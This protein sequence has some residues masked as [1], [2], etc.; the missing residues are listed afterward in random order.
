MK[1]DKRIYIFIFSSIFIF[2][3]IYIIKRTYKEGF[4]DEKIPKLIIQT[5]KNKDIPKQY[6]HLVDN[7]KNMN[8]TYE[9]KLYT[10]DDI[11]DFLKKNY[12]YYWKTFNRLPIFIQKMDFF[13]YIAIYHNGGFYFDLDIDFKFPIDDFLLDKECIFPVDETINPKACNQY[14]FE[15]FCENKMSILLGQYA[16]A[17]KPFNPFIKQLIDNIHNNIENIIN[18]NNKFE[19]TLYSR[20]VKQIFVYLTTG[21]DYVTQQYMNSN[22]KSQIFILDNSPNQH[23]GKYAEHK[24]FGTWK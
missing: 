17:S 2:I 15:Y 3:L 20:E 22:D 6:K 14:R 5:W 21:P 16:F 18:E 9:Y 4:M 8:P 12:P 24:C 10:D 13:R 11:E 19:N 1:I 23:F 7:L